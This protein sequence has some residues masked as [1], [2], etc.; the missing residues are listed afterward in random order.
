MFWK[1]ALSAYQLAIF[2]LLWVEF[3]LSEPFFAWHAFSVSLFL[4]FGESAYFWL[5]TN[6]EGLPAL[7]ALIYHPRKCL[8]LL[9]PAIATHHWAVCLQYDADNCD[10]TQYLK[11]KQG[12]T[13]LPVRGRSCTDE[14]YG[15]LDSH[16]HKFMGSIE[17]NESSITAA[18]SSHF[19][20]AVFN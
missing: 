19:S 17:M 2:M 4:P 13:L 8:H 11:H 9:L 1:M 3:F 6:F 16:T 7:N 15:P 5:R 10:K 12:V 20:T 18:E 14:F